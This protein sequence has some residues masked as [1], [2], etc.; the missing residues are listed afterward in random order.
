[1][2]YIIY[3]D[4]NFFH[5]QLPDSLYSLLPSFYPPFSLQNKKANKQK[6]IK[7]EIEKHKRYMHIKSI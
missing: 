2:F 4:D 5:Q 6:R 1:M 7:S 3:L